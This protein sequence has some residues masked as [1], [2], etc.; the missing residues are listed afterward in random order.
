MNEIV[1]RM[2][3]NQPVVSKHLG[4]LKQVGLV[5]E[6]KQGRF[7]V[8]RVNPEQ[9]KLIHDW[10]HQFEGYWSQQLDQLGEYLDT[11]QSKEISDDNE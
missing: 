4:V 6:S 3:W 7:R 5:L 9:L 2:G 11:I 1:G 8:Y 10:V